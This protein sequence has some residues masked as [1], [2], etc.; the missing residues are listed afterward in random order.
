MPQAHDSSGQDDKCGAAS[1]FEICGR[2]GGS[3]EPFRGSFR[4]RPLLM[5]I[6]RGL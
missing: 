5:H 4:K 1:Y 3:T 2:M 6:R